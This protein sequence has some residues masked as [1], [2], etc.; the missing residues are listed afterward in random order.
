[1]YSYENKEIHKWNKY[2]FLQKLCTLHWLVLTDCIT[3][4]CEELKELHYCCD[5][6][7]DFQQIYGKEPYTNIHGNCIYVYKTVFE[8]F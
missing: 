7:A 6:G 2:N 1:M 5:L 8:V 3:N 4:H